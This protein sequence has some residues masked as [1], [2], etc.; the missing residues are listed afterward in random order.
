M[1]E[2]P[3][4]AKKFTQK[5]NLE[6]H[7]T[8]AKNK[9]G[10]EIVEKPCCFQCKYCPK[11][12]VKNV[13]LKMH[14]LRDHE[15]ENEISLKDDKIK[16]LEHTIENIKEENINLKI[17]LKALQKE[18]TLLKETKI[19]SSNTNIINVNVKTIYVKSYSQTNYDHINVN[20][21]DNCVKNP[22]SGIPILIK[23]AHFDINHPENH[24]IIPINK[25][26]K[27]YEIVNGNKKYLIKEN[28]LTEFLIHS[29]RKQ[30]G[31]Y[32]ENNMKRYV[33]TAVDKCD[34]MLDT[35]FEAISSRNC[36]HTLS[37]ELCD[38]VKKILNDGFEMFR[39]ID[40]KKSFDYQMDPNNVEIPINNLIQIISES[41][42][43]LI[44]QTT[45]KEI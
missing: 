35:I 16:E 12:Y 19:S 40:K 33:S 24:N 21:Y 37:L 42:P 27:L 32:L 29:K 45:V 10:E 20:I 11:I 15:K 13:S 14:I 6:Y 28:N 30:I 18:I 25:R 22:Y 2:C 39:Q 4:C 8:K 26:D 43:K 44:T 9:C 5:H 38:N 36:Q 3:K 41:E 1:F 23:A 34:R 7:L 31:E 17:E